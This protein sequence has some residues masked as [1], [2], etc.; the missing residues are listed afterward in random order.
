VSIVLVTGS[1][2]LIGSEAVSYFCGLG[3]PTVGIDNDMRRIF[4]GESASTE[5]NRQRLVERWGAQYDHWNVDIR[6]QTG[7][8]RVFSRHGNEISLIINAAAQP[9]HDWAAREPQTDFAVNANGT[10]N[11][12]EQTRR[13]CPQGVFIFCSTNK[14]YGDNPN[15]LPFIELDQRWEIEPGHRFEPGIDESMS[16][17]F[18]KHS[19]FGVSKLAADMMV[20]EYGRYFELRTAVFRAGCLTGSSHSGAELHGFLSYLARCAA[21]GT[22][23]KIYGYKGKQVRDNL[24]GT[25][26]VR[27]FD[28]FYRNPRIGEVYNIGGGRESNCSVLEALAICEELTGR[29]VEHEHIEQNR[30]GDHIW[31]ISN[32]ARFREQYPGWRP[33]RNVRQIL[34]DILAVNSD[35]WLSETR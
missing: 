28:A 15:R 12:L 16:L 8:E 9:S 25:D 23:Y 18:C 21:T 35:R 22:R 2:G 1:T 24:D 11:L 32:T 19:I 34:T 29:P 7:L 20:Q 26:L 4:F 14:V 27:A 10:L 3:H 33:T 31:W 17:D 5:W 30:I 13:H 6:D